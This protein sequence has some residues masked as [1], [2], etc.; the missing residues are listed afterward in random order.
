VLTPDLGPVFSRMWPDDHPPGLPWGD[1]E[2]SRRMLAEHL[3]QSHDMASRRSSVIERHVETLH[4]IIGGPTS[5]VDLG[6][7]PGLY[8]AALAS[9]GHTCLGIDIGPASIA[10]ANENSGERCAHVL[11]DARTSDPGTGHGLAM[12]LFGQIDTF[13]PDDGALIL[14]RMRGALRDDGVIVLEVHDTAHVAT[15]GRSGTSWW[16]REPRVVVHLLWVSDP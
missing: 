7:G 5:V 12:M 2:F 3:D 11:G 8:T 4:G 1:A 14:H 9:R 16:W 13:S 10:H 6:C 15:V